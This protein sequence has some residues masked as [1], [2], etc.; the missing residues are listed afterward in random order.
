DRVALAHAVLLD[1]T[2][3]HVHVARAGQV[4]RRADERVVLEHVEDARDG[5][6]DVVF[7]DLGFEVVAHAGAA[8][9]A[10]ALVLLLLLVLLLCGLL[11]GLLTA[12]LR[13]LAT[14]GVTLFALRGARAAA[15]A[16]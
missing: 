5:D 15:V 3:R 1:L 16:P 13:R 8:A 6:E 2:E 14:R 12:S 10:L 7:K 4:A 11:C 9:T